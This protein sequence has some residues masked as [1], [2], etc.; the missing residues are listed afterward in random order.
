MAMYEYRQVYNTQ[1]SDQKIK[2]VP[3]GRLRQ[4]GVDKIITDFSEGNRNP[5]KG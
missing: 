5:T 2:K 1:C 3:K 4:R